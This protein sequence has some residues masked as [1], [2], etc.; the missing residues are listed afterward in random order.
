L[1]LLLQDTFYCNIGNNTISDLSLAAS[2]EKE[3]LPLIVIRNTS[4]EGGHTLVH[5]F[6]CENLVAKHFAYGNDNRWVSFQNIQCGRWQLSR[7][8]SMFFIQTGTSVMIKDCGSHNLNGPVNTGTYTCTAS[9]GVIAG[10]SIDHGIKVDDWVRLTNFSTA[11]DG[12]YKVTATGTDTIT[13]DPKPGEDLGTGTGDETVT[14]Q[15]FMADL[16]SIGHV[17]I[18]GNDNTFR[19]SACPPFRIKDCKDV[20]I[21]PYQLQDSDFF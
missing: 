8:K 12:F 14:V 19:K 5:D 1:F 20:V 6:F 10:T 13:V 9:T 18:E 2:T 17:L 21:S 3:T 15:P 7:T 4:A 16:E 11:I